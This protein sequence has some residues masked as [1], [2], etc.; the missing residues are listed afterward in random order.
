MERFQEVHRQSQDLF[1]R[2][3]AST[4]EAHSRSNIQTVQPKHDAH[5]QMPLSIPQTA[6]QAIGIAA[7][8]PD[9]NLVGE[10]DLVTPVSIASRLLAKTPQTSK[11]QPPP[12]TEAPSS[13]ANGSMVQS[14]STLSC[15]IQL[16]KFKL[17]TFN[18][19]PHQWPLFGSST[20]PQFTATHS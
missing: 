4:L 17:P 8:T 1:L 19:S 5:S 13:A 7:V 14:H 2:G 15:G 10:S 20:K 16:P 11:Q 9:V 18:V 6:H 12:P 3:L